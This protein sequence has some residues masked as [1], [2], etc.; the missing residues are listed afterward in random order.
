M[1]RDAGTV[2]N[3]VLDSD[4]FNNRDPA[5]PGGAGTIL[6]IKFGSGGGILIR[7][8]RAFRNADNGIDLG[9]F[10]SPVTVERN[11]SYGNGVN[12]WNLPNWSSNSVGYHLGGGDPPNNAAHMVRH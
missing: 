10:A 5:S 11:W 8:N 2:G 7:G 3:Q 1:L 9:Y 4:F 12:Y 6:A